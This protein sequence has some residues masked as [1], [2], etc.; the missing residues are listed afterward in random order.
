MIVLK[1]KK[2]REELRTILRKKIDILTVNQL[3]NNL[4]LIQDIL[5]D[6]IKIYEKS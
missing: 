6:G 4:E 3:E 1:I 5:K 2:K